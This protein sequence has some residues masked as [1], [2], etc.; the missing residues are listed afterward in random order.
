MKRTE[1]KPTGNSYEREA[2]E[3]GSVVKGIGLYLAER[4]NKRM[5]FS[6]I[7]LRK[8]KSSLHIT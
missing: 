1:G 7:D 5:I 4:G 8:K 2:V 3:L 6:S